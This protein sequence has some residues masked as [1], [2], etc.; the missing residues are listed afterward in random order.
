MS[1]QCNNC[2]YQQSTSQYANVGGD[3]NVSIIP[4]RRRYNPGAL[5]VTG[6]GAGTSTAISKVINVGSQ[7]AQTDSGSQFKASS[8][9]N[10]TTLQNIQKI[11]DVAAE[12]I[13]VVDTAKKSNIKLA[14][15]YQQQQL[16]NKQIANLNSL[17][18][19]SR[20]VDTSSSSGAKASEKKRKTSTRNRFK[21]MGTSLASSP[22]FQAQLSLLSPIKIKPQDME[23]SVFIPDNFDGTKVWKEYLQPVRKQGMCGSCYAFACIFV[24]ESRLSIYSKGKYNYQLSPSKMIYCSNPIETDEN[25]TRSE[26]ELIKNTLETAP[27]DYTTDQTIIKKN[28][29]SCSGETLISTWQ[30]LYRFGVPEDAC[31]GYGDNEN[32]APDNMTIKEI[33][34]RS[35]VDVLGSSFD[36][37][38]NKKKMVS[39]IAGGYYSLPNDEYKIRRDIYQFGPVSSGMI[40]Y[41]DFLDWSGL[42]IYEWDR[43]ALSVGG[44]AIVI[45]GWGEENNKKYWIVRNSWG[46]E[47]G[48][49]GYFKIL[50]G[51]NHCEIEENCFTGIPNVP[52]ARLFVEQPLFFQQEDYIYRYL[53]GVNDNGY[54]ETTLEMISAGKR[55]PK[56]FNKLLYDITAFPDFSK[57]YAG[58]TKEKENFIV[59][60]QQVTILNW[61]IVVIL[62]LIILLF[63]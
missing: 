55:P 22:L 14:T 13:Q 9:A 38:M 41:E 32:E 20:A 2:N 5:V 53:W 33:V 29:M 56:N 39:H 42:G 27:F 30:F 7:S 63:Y 3:S 48:D 11:I 46:A 49:N 61:R 21:T 24:L 59:E 18:K 58:E 54:K 23:A 16:Q 1:S 43:K 10:L 62:F 6:S 36:R 17:K 15:D 57:Y 44:H 12:V 4:P 26:E 45:V 60:D 37:C 40:I 52:G 35:C 19:A 28:L 47:W 25:D 51:S 8:K 50:R 31:V 34:E